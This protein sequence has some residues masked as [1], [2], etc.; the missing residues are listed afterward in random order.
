[1][2]ALNSVASLLWVRLETAELLSL[3]STVIFLAIC[4][5][6]LL[7]NF[8]LL[9]FSPVSVSLFDFVC[10]SGSLSPISVSLCSPVSTS[11]PYLSQHLSRLYIYP[12]FCLSVCLSLT[13][14]SVSLSIISV[15]SACLS[16]APVLVS[17]Q[18]L[19]SFLPS[20]STPLSLSLSPSLV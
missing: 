15:L 2:L 8:E 20:L 11:L 5:F 9:S 14:V 6:V 7:H 10:L 19:Y 18:L 12:P 4:K 13:P 17:R 3:F 1:M 16:L